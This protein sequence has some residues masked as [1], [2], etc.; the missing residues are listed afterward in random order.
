MN[1]LRHLPI[2]LKTRALRWI[3]RR[4]I[5]MPDGLMCGWFEFQHRE[6]RRALWSQGIG[7]I[8][9]DHLGWYQ[10]PPSDSLPERVLASLTR[11]PTCIEL[12]AT[13][14]EVEQLPAEAVAQIREKYAVYFN[15]TAACL[16]RA[17]DVSRPGA[18]G[19]VQGYES[20]NAVA[21][22]VALERGLPVIAFEN[23][24]LKNRALWDDH[25]A[26]TTNRN[27]AHNFYWRY[28]DTADAAQAEQYCAH[29]I[30]H[31]KQQ[32]SSEHLSP[33]QAY[34]GSTAKRQTLLFLGQVYTDSSVLFGIGA[35]RTPVN[36]IRELA[37]LAQIMNL[38]LWI[39]LHPK[40]I[41]GTSP[42]TGQPYKRLTYRKLMQDARFRELAHDSD[43]IMIDHENRYDTYDLMQK[44]DVAVTLNSQAG[45]EAAIRGVP[46]VVAGQAF[47]GGLG[48]TLEADCPAVLAVQVKKALRMEQ[49]ERDQTRLSTC[50]FTHIY[51]ERY[52]VEK[53]PSA[54]AKFIASRYFH[55]HGL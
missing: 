34:E 19:I 40:E 3:K 2:Q 9:L 5:A 22:Q 45:L 28:V 51:F 33:S 31:T 55:D 7:T 39:K 52:C 1:L 23:T 20:L 16:R 29:L 53:S 8:P 46:T 44:A 12:E 35:W 47:Y 41:S 54:I 32:K 50:I 42:V 43:R 36:L 17:F 25:S 18:V 10:D 30:A 37:E 49:K 4:R 21:R 13:L 38:N 27:L 15:K 11:Y 24:A 48:F 6:L 14:A 26:I